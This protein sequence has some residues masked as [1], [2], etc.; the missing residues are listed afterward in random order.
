[1]RGGKGE[2][3]RRGEDGRGWREKKEGA[4]EEEEEEE[5]EEEDCGVTTDDRYAHD[6]ACN[7]LQYGR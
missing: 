3:K 1:M 4:G 7:L 6:N 5:E 2:E